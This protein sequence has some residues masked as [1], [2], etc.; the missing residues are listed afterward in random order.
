M[1]ADQ[2]E[3]S[4]DDLRD[5]VFASGRGFVLCGVN[6]AAATERRSELVHYNDIQIDVV[7][8]GSGPAVV[9]LPSLARDSDDYDEVAEGLATADSVSCGRNRA[10]LGRSHRPMTKI[11]LHDSPATSPRWS[12]NWAAAKPSSSA[13]PTAIGWRG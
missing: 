6:V 12:R 4:R 9:L 1:P 5:G 11:T 13:M 7:I 10:A 8:D 2:G 3:D